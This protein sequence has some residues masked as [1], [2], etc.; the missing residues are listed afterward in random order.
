[1]C[2]NPGF[3]HFQISYH[4][5]THSYIST[6]PLKV[7]VFKLTCLYER[8][9]EYNIWWETPHS[10]WEKK[11]KKSSHLLRE[12][13]CDGE[14]DI[15]LVEWTPNWNKAM[16]TLAWLLLDE[17]IE[18]RWNRHALARF[19]WFY[20]CCFCNHLF[21]EPLVFGCAWGIHICFLSHR[22]PMNLSYCMH[23]IFI[24]DSFP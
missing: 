21:G 3:E 19:Y 24:P 1:M 16:M 5:H 4:Y 7:Y 22:A 8:V 15:K 18:N 9:W 23:S 10:S 2:L 20:L 6:R 13:V 12:I 11:K 14:M 17:W